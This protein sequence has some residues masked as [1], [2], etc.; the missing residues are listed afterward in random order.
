MESHDQ[1]LVYLES[2]LLSLYSLAIA[3]CCLDSLIS[4]SLS[5]YLIAKVILVNSNQLGDMLVK[6]TISVIPF[7]T[8][9]IIEHY[10][11]NSKSYK[12]HVF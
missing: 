1:F 2:F 8:K 9:R 4:G 11:H 12:L 3:S 6:E 7:A 5:G 10:K